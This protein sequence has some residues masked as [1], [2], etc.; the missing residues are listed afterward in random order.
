VTDLPNWQGGG[1]GATEGEIT[2]LATRVTSLEAA[3]S[4]SAGGGSTPG[5][6]GTSAVALGDRFG[7]T[8]TALGLSNGT[9]VKH[10]SRL[11]HLAAADA[12]TMQFAYSNLRGDAA[13]TIR[14]SA[15]H[16][17][18]NLGNSVLVQ[19]GFNGSTTGIVEPGCWLMTDPIALPVSKGATFGARTYLTVPAGKKWEFNHTQ[20]VNKDPWEAPMGGDGGV[21]G[22]SASDLTAPGSADISKSSGPF[23]GPQWVVFST[24]GRIVAIS[25]LG[26]SITNGG[27]SSTAEASYI[28]RATSGLIPCLMGTQGSATF[29]DFVAPVAPGASPGS[30]WSHARI[31]ATAG[32]YRYSGF[33]SNDIFVDVASLATVQARALAVWTILVSDAAKVLQGTVTPKTD[34][35]NTTPATGSTVRANFNA[36]LRAGAP[37]D[38]LTK[39]AVAI[40]TGGALLA[41]DDGHPLYLVLDKAAAV[42]SGNLWAS[43]S[44]QADG[45]HMTDAGHQAVADAIQPVLLALT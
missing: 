29:A 24:G 45:L 32:T 42:E 8:G 22:A 26:D 14:A 20:V 21:N 39:A 30:I 3:Q 36:W 1:G 40:G 41:G 18:V 37:I 16:G 28:K 43:S 35:G 31:A 23:Y 25:A 5:I 10:I 4:G 15:E 19:A 27:N 38:P 34:V 6:F 17:S 7:Q 12:L 13:Y 9:D 33:G 44:Y 2:A 11:V